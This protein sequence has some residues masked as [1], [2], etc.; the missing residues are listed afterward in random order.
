MHHYFY[1]F[2][3]LGWGWRGRGRDCRE[4]GLIFHWKNKS[5]ENTML[6]VLS[7]GILKGVLLESGTAEV[8]FGTDT[9][10]C[11]IV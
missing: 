11:E 7:A 8:R 2:Y 3:W 6:I 4:E 10:V 5:K 9:E 1:I